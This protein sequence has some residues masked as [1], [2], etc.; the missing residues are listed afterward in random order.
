M[1]T[2]VVLDSSESMR[3]GSTNKVTKFD[4]ASYIAASISY[5]VLKQ[6]D[7]AGLTIFDEGIVKELPSS[8]K[9]AHARAICHAIENASQKKKTDLSSILHHIAEKAP[10]RGLVV[11]ISDFFAQEEDILNGL[12]HL[13]H[14]RH[15]VLAMQVLDPFELTF[16][17]DRMTMFLGMEE[18]PDLLC[19]P[20]PLQKAYIEEITKFNRYLRHECT[21]RR[22]DFET[23]TSDQMLDV[24]LTTYLATRLARASK[25]G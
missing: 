7:T 6:G 2:Y 23:F 22:I 4:Y 24:A 18:Y 15:D 21:K 11:I 10:R 12:R 9:L 8:S 25:G 16:P 14:K 13:A 3:Y 20:R 17:F 19:D 1:T 5:M